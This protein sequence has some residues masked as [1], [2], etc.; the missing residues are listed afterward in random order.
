[1]RGSAGAGEFRGAEFS[2]GQVEKSQASRFW[3]RAPSA[4]RAVDGGK[5]VGLFG[6]KTGVESGARG[7]DACDF[8]AND[9][10]GELWVLH[11]LAD[12][13]PVALAEQAGDV[14]FRRVIRDAAH[15]RVALFVA[16]GEGDLQL[17]R[18]GF[19]VVEE[20]LVEVAE[21]E[22]E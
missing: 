11:L 6:G 16:G 17:L 18:G 10:F 19:S 14:V 13:D 22:E 21:A 12:G 1:V 5:I 4:R 15:G 3:L 9:L 7:E 8:A 2:S 20:E